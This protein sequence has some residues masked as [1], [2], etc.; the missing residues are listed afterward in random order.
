MFYMALLKCLTWNWIWD[1]AYLE[2]EHAN[3]VL[4]TCH[5]PA[6]LI[7]AELDCLYVVV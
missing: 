4:A 2:A 3:A 7:W 5:E 6:F 1:A